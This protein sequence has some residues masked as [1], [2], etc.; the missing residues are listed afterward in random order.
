ME[1]PRKGCF[2]NAYR[3]KGTFAMNEFNTYEFVVAQKKEGKVKVKRILAV[4]AYVL[5]FL[6]CAATLIVLN[7]PWFV[8]LLPLVEWMVIFFSWRYLSVEFE[9]SMTSGIATFSHIYGGRSRKTRLELNI[10]SCHEIAPLDDD[11]L[12]RLEQ[13]AI[14]KEYRFI[15][16]DDAPEVYYALFEEDGELAVVLFE[17]TQKAL[18]ILRFY[19]PMTVVTT[20]SR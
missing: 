19:N 5:F 15:S 4:V 17:P 6:I 8:A 3:P 9:Y 12:T 18:S 14:A 11:A 10:K 1:A 2:F 20:V 13:R 16:S 7:L